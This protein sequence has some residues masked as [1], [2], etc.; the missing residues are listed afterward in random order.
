MEVVLAG[1]KGEESKAELC[2]RY[3]V[4]TTTYYRWE[5]RFIDA[6]KEDLKD[7]RKNQPSNRE[8]KLECENDELKKALAEARLQ[9]RLLKKLDD[10]TSS[11]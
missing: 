7:R 8:R 2:S 1:L 9:V 5:E 6:G 10:M 4:S 3:G 11:R